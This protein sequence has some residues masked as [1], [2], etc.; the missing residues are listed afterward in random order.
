MLNEVYESTKSS[1]A[2]SI[3]SLKKDYSSLR[4]GKVNISVLDNIKVDYYGTPTGLNQVATVLASDAT[5]ITITP[6][7]K[8][9]IADID[10]SISQANIGVT[11]TSDGESVKLF[12]PPMTVEQRKESAKQA[13]A[14][15]ENAKVAIRNIRKNSNTQIKNLLKDKEITEDENKKALDT[16]Q[17]ITDDF[18]KNSDDVFKAKEADLLKV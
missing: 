2:K 12:F 5:T 13:K 8:N 18:I 4:S 7:E 1:M 11:P 10:K 14:M 16:I 9:L 17:K 6:W 3:E 15:T